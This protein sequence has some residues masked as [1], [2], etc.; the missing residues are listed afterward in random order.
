MITN[1]RKI[2][3]IRDVMK[4]GALQI[5]LDEALCFLDEFIAEHAAMREQLRYRLQSEEKAP[6]GT[7]VIERTN[8]GTVLIEPAKYVSPD[9]HWLPVPP[10]DKD[11]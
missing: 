4:H 2:E 7:E 10:L 1:E 6:I 8:G 3:I 11:P 5:E 9:S